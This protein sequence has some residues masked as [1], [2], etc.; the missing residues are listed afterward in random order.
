MLLIKDAGYSRRDIRGSTTQRVETRPRTDLVARIRR[1][2]PWVE[3]PSPVSVRVVEETEGMTE[4]EV[5]RTLV[6]HDEHERMKEE[7]VEDSQREIRRKAGNI[8]SQNNA[9]YTQ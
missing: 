4:K 9:N 3:N 1:Y 5:L 2:I 6:Y 7:N 8:G